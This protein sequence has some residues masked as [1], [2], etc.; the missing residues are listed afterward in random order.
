MFL[1]QGD[2]AMKKKDEL[3]NESKHVF[4]DTRKYRTDVPAVENSNGSVRYSSD[5]KTL[6]PLMTRNG[7]EIKADGSVEHYRPGDRPVPPK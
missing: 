6:G 3:T 4:C 2:A 7:G 5:G 1:N